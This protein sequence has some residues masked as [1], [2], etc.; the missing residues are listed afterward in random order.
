MTRFDMASPKKLYTRAV[1]PEAMRL[2]PL[3]GV[4]AIFA[5]ALSNRVEPD[6]CTRITKGWPK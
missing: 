5:G 6:F 2:R 3:H 1:D 4:Y